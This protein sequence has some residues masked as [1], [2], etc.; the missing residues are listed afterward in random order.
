M[1]LTLVNKMLFGLG[2]MVLLTLVVGLYAVVSL[3]QLRALQEEI[4]NRDLPAIEAA[5]GMIDSLLAQD[6]YH[7]RF[8]IL[9]DPA[10]AELFRQRGNEFGARIPDIGASAGPTARA[11]AEELHRRYVE[12]AALQQQALVAAGATADPAALEA[13][14]RQAFEA[15]LQ[16]LRDIESSVRTAQNQT[17]IK[18]HRL[19]QR[20]FTVTLTLCIVGFTFG[21]GFALLINST[22]VQSMR[23]IQEATQHIGLGQFDQALELQTTDEVQEL[24]ES[25][26]WMSRRLKDLEARRLDAN[27]LSRLP[28]NLAIERE[29]LLRLQGGKPFAFCLADIDNFKAYGDHYGYARGSEVLKRLSEIFG[30]TA[31][32]VGEPADF[33]GHIGGDDF[34]L[35]TEPERVDAFCKMIIAEFDA[36]VPVLY[37][38]PDRARGFIVA[39]DRRDVEQSFPL[40]T[41]SIAVVTNQ[42][43]PITNPGQVA[44]VAAQLKQYAKSFP[45][46]VYV[47]DQRRAG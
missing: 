25:F 41:I 19:S 29:L 14:T 12:H 24:A 10:V 23:Q 21:L 31:R 3:N 30:Y 22:F 7:N 4:V 36:M 32:A 45:R 15:L 39:L 28:G 1:R 44:Q 8:L 43:R 33:I 17:S 5:S 46:S 42:N 40:M 20:A 37:D 2:L 13:A 27:P 38:E 9:R 18:A 6:L 16:S 34:V 47:V 35:I 11:R 26:R